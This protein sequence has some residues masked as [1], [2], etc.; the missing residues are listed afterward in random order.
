MIAVDTGFLYALADRSD[1]WH[2]RAL[3]QV[4]TAQ[5]GWLT[6]WSVLTETTHLLQRRLG[7]EF[8]IA[9]MREVADGALHVWEI[10]PAA[11][12]RMPTLMQR[13]ANLPMDLADAS[14]VLL[15]EHLG[16]GR[17]LTTDQRDF[18]A[19]RWKSQKPFHNLLDDPTAYPA[20][21]PH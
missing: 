21:P 14:M 9:L 17:I 7:T 13:Y 16:H 15:A 1:A 2:Q 11:R 18:G 5:E 8:A 6:T 3:A 4:N 20:T 19:Y 12:T 10:A